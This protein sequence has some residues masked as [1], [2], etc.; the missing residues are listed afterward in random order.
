MKNNCTKTSR[1]KVK[2]KTKSKMV[3]SVVTSNI[4]NTFYEGDNT[5]WIHEL[6]TLFKTKDDILHS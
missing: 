3:G 6:Y 1:P 4:R 5:K 2:K